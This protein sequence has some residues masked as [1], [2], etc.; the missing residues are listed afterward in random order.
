MKKLT[1][2]MIVKNEEMY[3]D[4]CLS[5]IKPILDS[6]DSELIITDTGSTDRTVEIAGKYADKV[7][8]FDW[9]NDFAAARNSNLRN[10]Q[11]EW[12]MFVDCDDIW[13]DCSDIIQFFNS[14]EYRQYHSAS[15]IYR[16]IFSPDKTSFSDQQ[17][18]RMAERTPE[19]RFVGR[20]HENLYPLKKPIRILN[21]IIDHYG[22]LYG[23]GNSAEEK[24][25]RNETLLLEELGEMPESDERIPFIYFYLFEAMRN[26]EP[27]KAADYLNRG[28]DI[29]FRNG[30]ENVVPLLADKIGVLFPAERYDELL[31]LCNNYFSLDLRKKH[32]T[33]DAE[34]YAAKALSLANTGR[35]GD[36]CDVFETFFDAYGLMKTSGAE[37]DDKFIITPVLSGAANFVNV[38]KKY[39]ACCI[40]AGRI[41]E[42]AERLV[43]TDLTD[44]PADNDSIAFIVENEIGLMSRMGYDLAPAF[45]GNLND[46]GRI[47]FKN[48]LCGILFV[49]DKKEDIIS[50]LKT[51]GSG[52]ENLTEKITVYNEYFV[53]R[54]VSEDDVC[55]YAEKY[56]MDG[57]H[58]LLLIMMQC[59]MDISRLFHIADFDPMICVKRCCD[60]IYGFY[61]TAA[62]YGAEYIS[63][64]D[65][66][67]MAAK[68][69]EY[70]MKCAIAVSRG[71]EPLIDVYAGFGTKYAEV[72]G[73][74]D[75]PAEIRAAFLMAKAQR[76]RRDRNYKECFSVMKEMLSA[77]DGI[78]AVIE[79][80]QK[81]VVKEYE[82]SINNLSEMDR[83]AIQIKRNIRNFIAVG[84]YE[85]A[86]KT[87]TEYSVINPGDPEIIELRGLVK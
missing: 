75:M 21:D 2:G 37:D 24:A 4:K 71:I 74:D 10:A 44:Y 8:H 80:Y 70:C 84:N 50:T 77:Y 46:F 26:V 63:P 85:A 78:A 86:K 83:L 13:E 20:I 28:I 40:D 61:D 53:E 14:G 39:M 66:L 67:A 25:H 69:Y 82:N 9:I 17:V 32:Y 58:D 76:A 1:I 43:K 72:V 42:L 56:G 34:M 48:S 16:N 81:I 38:V 51:I 47:V 22:Y 19:L 79:E 49:D 57:N 73:N 65:G 18:V 29:A 12:N 45:Y 55:A 6:V 62:D 64:S 60:Y 68:I 23:S 59:G 30:N 27:Q 33:A 5:S 11:G 3:L 31:E 35:N 15:Y 87:L 41:G 52:N 54:A 7:L 36:A